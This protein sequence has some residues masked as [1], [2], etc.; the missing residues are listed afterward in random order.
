M[1]NSFR[2]G[3]LQK[4]PSV[5]DAQK[6]FNIFYADMKNAPKFGAFGLPI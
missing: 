2:L 6:T 1:G 5:D 4:K 3:K